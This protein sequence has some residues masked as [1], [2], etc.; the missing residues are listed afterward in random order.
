[1]KKLTALA[2]LATITSTSLAA[3]DPWF[4]TNKPVKCGPFREIVQIVIG[5]PFTEQPLWVGH[6][7]VDPTSF[8]LFRNHKTNTWTL[9]QYGKEVGCVLGMGA[10]DNLYAPDLKN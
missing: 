9:V 1:M 10:G 3:T 6:S 2:I 7:G 5:E 8:T 4:E